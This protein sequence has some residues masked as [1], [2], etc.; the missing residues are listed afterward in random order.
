MIAFSSALLGGSDVFV[1]VTADVI[2][3]TSNGTR[4]YAWRSHQLKRKQ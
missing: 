2:R 4:L 3:S 1:T